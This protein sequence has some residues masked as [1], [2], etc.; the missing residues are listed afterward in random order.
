M[1]M[2]AHAEPHSSKPVA[3]RPR[4]MDSAPPNEG[5]ATMDAVAGRGPACGR[6]RRVRARLGSQVQASPSGRGCPRARSVARHGS[7]P[8]AGR[9]RAVHTQGA[10]ARRRCPARDQDSTVP[11]AEW[12]S[13]ARRKKCCPARASIRAGDRPTHPRKGC[14]FRELWFLGPG[15]QSGCAPLTIA[16][17]PAARPVEGHPRTPDMR[18]RP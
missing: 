14:R 9:A 11:S 4:T 17:G 10:V 6:E 18:E 1:V 7:A 8:I 12:R 16:A 2:R 13:F 5:C 15:W 3:H